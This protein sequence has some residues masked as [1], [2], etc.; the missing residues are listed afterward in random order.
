MDGSPHDGSAAFNREKALQDARQLSAYYTPQVVADQLAQ[1]AIRSGNESVLEPSAGGGALVDAVMRRTAELTA[2][3]FGGRLLACDINESALRDLRQRIG[4]RAAYHAGDF[5]DLHP[6]TTAGSFDVVI[7]NPPFTRNHAIPAE[8]R[9]DLRKRF[10]V[11]GAAGLWVHFL[12]HAMS[13]LAENGRLVSLVPAVAGS[14]RYGKQ[15]IDRLKQHFDAV[16][17]Q[18]LESKP[19]WHIPAD[20]RGAIIFAEGYHREVGGMARGSGVTLGTQDDFTRLMSLALPLGQLAS[21]SIGAVTGRNRVFLLSEAQRVEAGIPRADVRP[22]VSRA[23]H[24]EGLYVSSTRLEEL[25]RHGERTWLLAPERMT[26]TVERHLNQ[27][28]IEDRTSVAWFRKRSPWW[29]IDTG[30]DCDALFTYMNHIGPRLTLS[31]KGV[32]CTNTLHRV[33]FHPAISTEQQ[34]WTAI[35]LLTTFGQLAAERTGRVYGG[36]VLKFE[37]SEA[38]QIPIFVND[39]HIPKRVLAAVDLALKAG[40]WEGAT[41]LADEAVLPAVAGPDWLGL[42]KRLQTELKVLR[43]RRWGRAAQP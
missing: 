33:K 16:S 28:S 7:A 19:E 35:S 1:W 5:L 6:N 40:D 2:K 41:R 17:I 32:S 29:K 27:V 4:G 8:R 24:L 9:S 38:R 12:L 11:T 31:G 36:G 20:E 10:G 22:V 43:Q 21:L 18:P 13:F 34:E 3:P 30:A 15:L 37:L 39:L 23:S 42:A 26:Q 14:T 25:A